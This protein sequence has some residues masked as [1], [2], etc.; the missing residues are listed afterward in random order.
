MWY[1][2]SAL[3]GL[4]SLV[5]Y[6]FRSLNPFWPLF[7]V[8]SLTGVL[9][10]I[11]FRR[12]SNQKGIREAKDR[13]KAHLLEIWLF[14]DNPSIVLSAQKRLLF[15]N[16]KYMQHALKPMLFM[17][18]PVAVVL[19]QLE[20]WFGYKPLDIGDS[21]IISVKLNKDAKN[22]PSGISLESDGGLSIETPPL[23]MPEDGE[24]NWR[25]RAKAAG[26]HKILLNVAG[27]KISKE[28]TVSRGKLTQLSK[29][30]VGSHFWDVLLNPGERPIDGNS[31][32]RSIGINY[33]SRSIEIIGWRLHWLVLYLVL[34]I[35]AG[36]ALKGVFKTEI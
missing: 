17:F 7:I 23:N 13:I 18:I 25:V 2:N 36:F 34:S 35:I 15:Y 20:G 11:I 9:M 22:L 14:K 12:T 27:Q 16:T 10:L 31:Y 19:V 8:S 4:F 32:V 3:N 30:R 1:I 29:V 6:P 5:F 21:A 28:I 33:R 26:E 24:M